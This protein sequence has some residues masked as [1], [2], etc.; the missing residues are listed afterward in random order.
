MKKQ[1][2]MTTAMAAALLAL[3][4]CS[5]DNGWEDVVADKDTAV[6]VD[7]EGKRVEDAQCTRQASTG[8]GTGAGAGLSS[9]FL[10]YYL[11]RNA[12]VPYYGDSV[13]D[14][15]FANSGSYA[16][17]AGAAYSLA[18]QAANITRSR[19]VSR[20]GMGSR[21]SFFGSGRS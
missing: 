8:S 20:G 11:G 15:R 3:P 21:G 7:K 10:W 17:R 13:R 1:L 18:P 4:G 12:R 5:S 6:C 19:A 9:A 2:S 16:P 14:Q